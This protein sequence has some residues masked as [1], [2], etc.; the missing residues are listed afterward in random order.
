MPVADALSA[1]VVTP[2][3]LERGSPPIGRC[4]CPTRHFL[5]IYVTLLASALVTRISHVI[6]TPGFT[7]GLEEKPVMCHAFLYIYTLHSLE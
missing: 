7:R 6:M 1:G 5:G 3:Y 4:I 2:D